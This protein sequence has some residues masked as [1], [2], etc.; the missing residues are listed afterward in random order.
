MSLNEYDN[1][2]IKYYQDNVKERNWHSLQLVKTLTERINKKWSGD[3]KASLQTLL[4]EIRNTGPSYLCPLM[5]LIH[6]YNGDIHLGI[7]QSLPYMEE[8]ELLNLLHIIQRIDNDMRGLPYASG[9]FLSSA[10]SSTTNNN[11]RQLSRNSISNE[12]ELS[13]QIHALQRHLAHL[14]EWKEEGELLKVWERIQ[15]MDKVIYRDDIEKQLQVKVEGDSTPIKINRAMYLALQTMSLVKLREF[16]FLLHEIDKEKLLVVLQENKNKYKYIQAVLP[17]ESLSSHWKTMLNLNHLYVYGKYA[18]QYGYQ[19]KHYTDY[20]SSFFINHKV[21]TIK[22]YLS[23]DTIEPWM[24]TVLLPN[25]Q[26]G[27]VMRDFNQYRKWPYK[28]PG[29]Q[30]M[31]YLMWRKIAHLPRDQDDLFI[32]Y[33]SSLPVN[34]GL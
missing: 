27:I 18:R 29:N 16:K 17:P 10:S 23:I 14:L 6:S 11:G 22:S 12:D 32:R 24:K 3:G 13:C 8:S 30:L 25:H 5:D 31:D 15:S 20:L 28:Y 33:L 2:K 7:I 1:D 4:L 21:T 9:E 19:E 34:S 26:P